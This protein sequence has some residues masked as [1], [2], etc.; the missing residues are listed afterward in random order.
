MP[1]VLVRSPPHMH[2]EGEIWRAYLNERLEPARVRIRLVRDASIAN[3][4]LVQ[5]VGRPYEAL[6]VSSEHQTERS[7]GRWS[8][9]PTPS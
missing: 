2:V 3:E 5:I 7:E 6:R 1:P 4:V 9:A 8:S